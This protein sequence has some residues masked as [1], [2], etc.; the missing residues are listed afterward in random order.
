M[1]TFGELQLK[2]F[3]SIGAVTQT[4]DLNTDKLTLILGEN[5]DLGGGGTRNGTGKTTIL[6]GLSYALFGVPINNIKKDNLINRTNAKGM[7]VKFNFSVGAVNYRIERGR[8]PTFLKFY[9]DDKEQS[10]EETNDS[11]GDSRETQDV[12]ER[13]LRMSP[14]MF[15]HVV[16]LN[17][18]T[19]PFL[20]LKAADQRI[21]IEQL[22]GITILSEKAEIIKKLNTNIKLSIQME[23]IKVKSEQEANVRIQ[24]QIESLKRRQQAWI[25]KHDEELTNLVDEYDRLSKVD[26]VAELQSHKDLLV[27]NSLLAEKTQYDALLAKQAAWAYSQSD[28][29]DNRS[30]KLDLLKSIDIEIELQAHKDLALYNQQVIEQAAVKKEIAR[31]ESEY[32][33]ETKIG[34]T[35]LEEIK[36]LNENKCYACGQD[37]HD[38]NHESVL[39]TKEEAEAAYQIRK[40]QLSNDLNDLKELVVVLGDKPVTEYKSESDAIKHSYQLLNL[41]IEIDAKRQ[42]SNPYDEQ[43]LEFN[44][45]SIDLGPKPTTHYKTEAEAI[46]HSSRVDSLLD[47]ITNKNDEIEPYSEQISEM[48]RN[49]IQKISFDTINELT[50]VMQHQ[51]Y[52]LDLLTNKKS[53]VRKKII[54]QNL[55]YL[56]SRLAYYLS[57]LVLPYEVTF[58]ND[59]SVEITDLGR[60]SDFDNL[61]RGERNRVILALNFSFRDVFETLFQSSN[62]VFVDELLDNG[63]DPA[64]VELA[65]DLLKHMSMALN[66]SVFLVSHRDDV[67]GAVDST[68]KVIKENGYTRYENENE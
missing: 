61:S 66:K 33:K 46:K 24:E 23:N 62:L 55:P 1:I 26:I 15:R 57:A 50:R 9:V 65:L 40:T 58:M 38:D 29:I 36:T 37:F 3:L 53:F 22:L 7:V 63:L 30:K 67:V 14:D 42:E 56:N 18:Y 4:V 51:E 13:V 35:L 52:L 34:E 41:V 31:L 54:E 6:Q 45:T 68:L 28:I 21:I 11:Q 44:D 8:K 43:L 47:Q 5:L 59:L 10:T 19:D 60:E 25:S 12:I 49:A 2:N 39:R 20:A 32:A 64:G 16:G 48:E 27:Y 17:T